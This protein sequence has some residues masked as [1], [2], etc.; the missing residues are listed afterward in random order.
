[1]KE[2]RD[3][4]ISAFLSFLDRANPQHIQ[5]ASFAQTQRAIALVDGD[6]DIDLN[7]PLLNENEA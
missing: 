7:A 4:V 6:L 1:V 5:A 2:E 3:P